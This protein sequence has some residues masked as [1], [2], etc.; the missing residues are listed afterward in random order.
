MTVTCNLDIY[1]P[2][3]FKF[4]PALTSVPLTCNSPVQCLLRC[5]QMSL[6]TQKER[7]LNHYVALQPDLLR[8]LMI[9][10]YIYYFTAFYKP[11]ENS[12]LYR[13]STP[14]L[15]SATKPPPPPTSRRYFSL[16]F[17][18]TW[19][20][21]SYFL[22]CSVWDVCLG[23]SATCWQLLHLCISLRVSSRSGIKFVSLH[24][25]LHLILDF[26]SVWFHGYWCWT[27]T[28]ESCW[29]EV[30]TG[31]MCSEGWCHAVT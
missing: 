16:S 22:I 23:N 25:V 18:P 3:L 31:R 27:Q 1:T 26:H 30:K 15:Q 13:L 10:R 14:Q 7:W 24:I 9:H 8:A 4:S 6:F 12:E 21:K 29:R 17:A 20:E 2:T 11:S 28:L 19:S 5:G